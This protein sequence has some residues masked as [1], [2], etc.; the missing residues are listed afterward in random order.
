ML[1][2]KSACVLHLSVLVFKWKRKKQKYSEVK[3]ELDFPFPIHILNEII[4]Q[5]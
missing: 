5:Q 4:P 3:T 2:E 1:G